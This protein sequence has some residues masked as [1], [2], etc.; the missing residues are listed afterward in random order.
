V[1]SLKRR[2]FHQEQLT[3]D[4]KKEASR[5]MSRIHD[6]EES[7]TQV[8]A[9]IQLQAQ[10]QMHGPLAANV[11][12][13]RNSR[14]LAS[15]MSGTAAGNNVTSV[16]GAISAGAQLG[17]PSPYV[18]STPISIQPGPTS[19]FS[20]ASP[21]R[22]SSIN[23]GASQGS[24]RGREGGGGGG[25][26]RG[27][28][29]LSPAPAM[30]LMDLAQSDLHSSSA[31]PTSTFY[32]GAVS[33]SESKGEGRDRGSNSNG[34][35]HQPRLQQQQSVRSGRSASPPVFSTSMRGGPSGGMRPG[36]GGGGGGGGGVRSASPSAF[37]DL[38]GNSTKGVGVKSNSPYMVTAPAWN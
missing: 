32:S 36:G 8:H 7:T 35:L 21:P 23:T 3:Y 13:N 1:E 9:Q 29:I 33:V 11:N 27:G 24:V 19:A 15:Y 5:L 10:T 4:A 20:S 37:S 26:G 28:N 12:A 38:R 16:K 17:T 6:L 22:L 34:G 14:D 25:G 30:E 31:R 2:L 18:T